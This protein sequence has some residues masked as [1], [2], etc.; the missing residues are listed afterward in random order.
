MKNTIAITSSIIHQKII[1]SQLVNVVRA[2]CMRKIYS[3][4]LFLLFSL[5]GFSQKSKVSL[6][7]NSTAGEVHWQILDANFQ[8]TVSSNEFPGDDSVNI[9]LESYKYYTL[10]LNVTSIRLPDTLLFKLSVWGEPVLFIKTDVSEGTHTFRFYTGVPPDGSKIIGGSTVSISSFPWQIFLISG[11]YQCGGTI[12]NKK[13]ILTAAHCVKD[14]TTNET[15]SPTLMIVRVG[16]NNPYNGTGKPYSVSQVYP[17]ESYNPSTYLN[18]IALLKLKDSINFANATPIKMVTTYD[19]ANGMIDPGVLSTVSG[20][21]LTSVNPQILPLTLQAVS[22]PIVY[23]SNA[24]AIFGSVPV[25]DII[26]G[27]HNGGKDACSGDSGGPLTVP[28]Y[29]EVKIAGIVS[30]GDENCTTYGGYTNV[31]MF[32]TW[33]YSKTGIQQDYIPPKPVGDSVLCYGV[34]STTYTVGAIAGASAYEWQLSPSYAGT[35]A[36]TAGDATVTWS[37]DYVGPVSLM[38]RVTV[39]GAA[40]EWAF[41][42]INIYQNTQ[43]ISQSTDLVNCEGTQMTVS[44]WAVGDR[45]KYSWYRNDTLQS[46]FIMNKIVRLNALPAYS[47]NYYCKVKGTCGTITS[48]PVSVIVHPAT[49]IAY[50]PADTAVNF[51]SDVVFNSKSSGHNPVYKWWKNDTL[52]AN[53]DVAQLSLSSVNATDIGLYKFMITGTCGTLTSSSIYLYVKEDRQQGSP[54]VYLWPT[55]ATDFL[56][57][58]L[59]TEDVFT[60]RI[61][62]PAGKV[63]LEKKGCQHQTTINVSHFAGGVYIVEVS[64]TSFRR[65]LRMIRK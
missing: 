41:R 31:S 60:V 52:L 39:N 10:V 6:E 63:I 20:W 18:D 50:S 12:I 58:A 43:I 23:P 49:K 54:G 32:R 21:G 26:A 7:R 48:T 8:T 17:H 35:V 15:I 4:F 22:L 13:W 2:F 38:V 40:S 64:G 24:E 27:Y 33:I 36:N 14:K 37:A 61:I 65:S 51:G 28:V 53:S 1:N 57:V 56:N 46:D 34:S 9:L 3:I 25:T 19:A 16:A 11:N 55:L 44:V 29:D 45:L 42:K 59:E 5:N 47:G 62:S 30:W